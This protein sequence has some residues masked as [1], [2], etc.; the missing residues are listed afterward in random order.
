ML[1]RQTEA[2]MTLTPFWQDYFFGSSSGRFNISEFAADQNLEG[3]NIS[4]RYPILRID[5]IARLY[6]HTNASTAQR[7]GSWSSPFAMT[8]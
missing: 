4:N 1:F 2:N 5:V 8:E 7:H 3:K 6:M